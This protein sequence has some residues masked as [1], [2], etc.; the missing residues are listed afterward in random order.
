[1]PGLPPSDSCMQL[2]KT[3]TPADVWVESMPFSETREYVKKVLAFTAIFEQRLNSATTP[4]A[5]R[6]PN[7]K[8]TGAP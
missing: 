3:E 2:P 6:M 7:I 1:M 4:L 8:A 5:T